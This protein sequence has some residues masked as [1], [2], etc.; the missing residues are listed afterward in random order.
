MEKS[1]VAVLALSLGCYITNAQDI[2]DSLKYRSIGPEEFMESYRN[3]SRKVLIDVREPVEIRRGR[4]KEAINIPS[5][6]GYGLAADTTN[7]N[8]ALFLYCHSGGRSKRAAIYFYNKGF[9]KLYSLDGGMVAWK[10]DGMPA[11]R[12]KRRKR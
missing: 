4:I 1:I 3:E 9:R 8:T 7:R 5:T 6:G 10:R 2:A 11:V 12:G